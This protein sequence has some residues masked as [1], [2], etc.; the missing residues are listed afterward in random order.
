MRDAGFADVRV[1]RMA[2]DFAIVRGTVP[3]EGAP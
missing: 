2:G 3:A 1:E